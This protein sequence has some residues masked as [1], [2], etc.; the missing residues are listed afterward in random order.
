MA[1]HLGLFSSAT[2]SGSSSSSIH[3]YYTKDSSLL[4]N[5]ASFSVVVAGEYNA[6]KSTLINALTGTNLLET[7]SLPTTDTI[8]LITHDNHSDAVND[9]DDATIHKQLQNIPG[10]VHHSVSNV[11]LL[12]DLTLV[13]TPGTNAVLRDHTATT[14]AL[15]PNADLILFVTSADRP[16]SESERTLLLSICH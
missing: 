11:P 10:I 15:L 3:S 5:L 1:Q 13:D 7:G 6:G 14:L 16:F 8:T 12:Q 9:A 2:R 4:Q